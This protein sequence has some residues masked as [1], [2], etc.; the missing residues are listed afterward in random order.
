MSAIR[1][2]LLLKSQNGAEQKQCERRRKSSMTP[3]GE[4]VQGVPLSDVAPRSID[5]NGNLEQTASQPSR[6]SA[7]QIAEI[8]RTHQ[9]TSGTTHGQMNDFRKCAS[10]PELPASSLDASETK[11]HLEDV[12]D[13]QPLILRVTRSLCPSLHHR[14]QHAMSTHCTETL[15]PQ[16]DGAQPCDSSASSTTL[17]KPVSYLSF[18][19]IVGRNSAFRGLS[20]NHIEDLGG[21]EYRALTA[22]LWIVPLVRLPLGLDVHGHY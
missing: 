7:L 5:P 12:P 2:S 21:I 16:A 22:L 3:R 9:R 15:V 20:A 6:T 10:T 13:P 18:R 8:S 14:L 1:D 11:E 17:F 19:A 4:D